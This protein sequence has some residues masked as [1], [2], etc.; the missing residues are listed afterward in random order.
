MGHPLGR[1]QARGQP[2]APRAVAT[3]C[4]VVLGGSPRTGCAAGRGRATR[5]AETAGSGCRV[6]AQPLPVSL[7]RIVKGGVSAF[8]C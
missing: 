7:V 5:L 4:R 8:E 1:T 2:P 6:L 3:Q